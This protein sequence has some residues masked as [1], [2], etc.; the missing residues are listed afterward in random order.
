MGVVAEMIVQ[1]IPKNGVVMGVRGVEEVNVLRRE[2]HVVLLAVVAPEEV[3]FE[4]VLNSMFEEF[5]KNVEEKIKMTCDAGKKKVLIRTYNLPGHRK[6]SV[7]FVTDED[8]EFHYDQQFLMRGPYDAKTRTYDSQYF[9][10][11]SLRCVRDMINDKCNPFKVK[12]YIQPKS[13][14]VQVYLI[15]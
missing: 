6:N 10:R 2:H 11:F 12:E 13:D 4:R 7:W 14:M 8:Q 9:Q 15:W 5:T 1:L 3:R